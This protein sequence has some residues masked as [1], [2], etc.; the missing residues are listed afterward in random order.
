[1]WVFYGDGQKEDLRVHLYDDLLCLISAANK[2]EIE[3]NANVRGREGGLH[4]HEKT[5]PEISGVGPQ[6]QN[7]EALF[8]H[9]YNT[10]SRN[11]LQLCLNSPAV[12]FSGAFC[13][14]LYHP[15]FYCGLFYSHGN[16]LLIRCLYVEGNNSQS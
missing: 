13:P 14:K 2:A 7:P 5:E 6:N 16:H 15:V 3:Q 11:C 12:L 1:M 10:F 9:V 8:V 4:S